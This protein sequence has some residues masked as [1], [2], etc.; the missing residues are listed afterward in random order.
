M[1][2]EGKKVEDIARERNLVTGTIETHLI[3]FISTGEVDVLELI[4]KEKFDRITG[5]A[6]AEP[7]IGS[8][9]LKEKLGDNYSWNDIRAVMAKRAADANQEEPQ[10]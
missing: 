10:Q 3:G 2:R 7:G 4:S 6:E 8:S 9:A 1:F 5:L